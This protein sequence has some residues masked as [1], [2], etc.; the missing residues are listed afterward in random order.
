MLCKTV[1]DHY[2]F[3]S[4]LHCWKQGSETASNQQGKKSL[5]I[6]IVSRVFGEANGVKINTARRTKRWR[7]RKKKKK[8]QQCNLLKCALK[9][10]KKKIIRKPDG[11]NCADYSG[12]AKTKPS[13]IK[14]SLWEANQD[15]WMKHHWH[16]SN[17]PD[18]LTSRIQQDLEEGLY[19][20]LATGSLPR[21]LI[22]QNKFISESSWK[23]NKAELLSNQLFFFG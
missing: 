17:H 14:K 9:S 19:L 12:S 8:T 3:S 18:M 6:T 21:F 1:P 4:V 22:Q 15:S 23:H 16:R 10:Q 2:W 13:S 7:A 20:F 5:S 11:R